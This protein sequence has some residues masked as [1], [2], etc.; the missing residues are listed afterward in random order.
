MMAESKKKHPL[1]G[2]SKEKCDFAINQVFV[3]RQRL[4]KRLASSAV[5]SQVRT[6][7][8]LEVVFYVVMPY[9]GHQQ[10]L[11]HWKFSHAHQYVAQGL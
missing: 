3:M 11:H 2:Y 1:L 7:K 4:G 6:E 8:L 5:N 10:S 9:Q